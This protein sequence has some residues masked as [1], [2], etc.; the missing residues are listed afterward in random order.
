[1]THTPHKVYYFIFN[2][3]MF[4]RDRDWLFRRAIFFVCLLINLS[5]AMLRIGAIMWLF[6][7][8]FDFN[9]KMF[10]LLRLER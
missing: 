6:I 9:N 2:M 4:N 1:M 8:W 3:S 10:E 5:L 7:C